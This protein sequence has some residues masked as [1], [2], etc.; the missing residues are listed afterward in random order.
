MNGRRFEHRAA[1]VSLVTGLSTI[2]TVAF[3]LISVSICLKNRGEETYGSWLALFS[4][5]TLRRSL[6]RRNSIVPAFDPSSLMMSSQS[7]SD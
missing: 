7:G 1:K 6:E 3:Q 5:F 2:L 4:A